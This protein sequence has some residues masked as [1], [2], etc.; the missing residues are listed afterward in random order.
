MKQ[1]IV[2]FSR[3]NMKKR[4][5]EDAGNSAYKT[6]RT[7]GD[8]VYLHRITKNTNLAITLCIPDTM[9]KSQDLTSQHGLGKLYDYIDTL[10]KEDLELL[11]KAFQ[12]PKVIETF[13]FWTVTPSHLKSRLELLARIEERLRVKV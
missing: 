11:K 3:E 12:R 9:S 8:L 4:T 5:I 10:E 7:F 6:Y 1:I 13:R 2:Y